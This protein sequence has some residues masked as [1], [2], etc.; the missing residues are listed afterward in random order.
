MYRWNDRRGMEHWLRLGEEKFREWLTLLY[1]WERLFFRCIHSDNSVLRRRH[2]MLWSA[3][4][5]HKGYFHKRLHGATGQWCN[6]AWR[7][8]PEA[9]RWIIWA[10]GFLVR[11][12]AA[13]LRTT[14]VCRYFNLTD[15]DSS[16]LETNDYDG[17]QRWGFPLSNHH[18]LVLRNIIAW[19]THRCV[20][21]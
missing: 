12:L 19:R 14:K 16:S 2:T 11:S 17:N 6:W 10:K 20:F 15:C 18:L 9:A 4:K 5:W 1:A 13:W 8:W 7:R 21:V 3:V